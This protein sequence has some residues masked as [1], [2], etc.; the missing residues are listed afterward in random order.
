MALGDG[1]AMKMT[2]SN[3]YSPNG[4]NIHKVGIE[5]DVVIEAEK[6]ENDNQLDKAVEIIKGKMQ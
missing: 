1:T 3:Y 4:T 2:V 5:P 6:G